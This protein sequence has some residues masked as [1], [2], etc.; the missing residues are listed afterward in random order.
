MDVQSHTYTQVLASSGL[1]F[2]IKCIRASRGIA[3]AIKE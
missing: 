2:P 1:L 3:F